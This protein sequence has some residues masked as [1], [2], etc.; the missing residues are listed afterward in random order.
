MGLEAVLDEE[1]GKQ[2]SKGVFFVNEKP[3]HRQRNVI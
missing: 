2:D 1:S 3:A